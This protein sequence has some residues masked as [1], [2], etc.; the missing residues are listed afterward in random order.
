MLD[1]HQYKANQDT[2]RRLLYSQA[3]GYTHRYTAWYVITR[4]GGVLLAFFTCP[5]VALFMSGMSEGALLLFAAFGMVAGVFV[6]MLSIVFILMWDSWQRGK[7]L[8]REL[9]RRGELCRG[10][11]IDKWHNYGDHGQSDFVHYHVAYRYGN[12]EVRQEVGSFTHWRLRPGKD[13]RVRYLS[14]NPQVARLE[15]YR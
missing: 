15:D 5:M 11:I 12:H 7:E 6:V 1:I 2:K 13:V 10:I 4:V 14:D 8:A 9:D 3:A